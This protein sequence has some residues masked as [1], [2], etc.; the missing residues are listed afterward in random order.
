[1]KWRNRGVVALL[2]LGYCTYFIAYP[3]LRDHGYLTWGIPQDTPPAV[4]RT[5][6]ARYVKLALLDR[7][8]PLDRRS[9]DPR[10]LSV[11]EIF[12]GMR[13]LSYGR[14]ALELAGTR[15]DS[16]CASAVWGD[17]VR[18]ALARG[19]CD[20][21]IRGQYRA[22]EVGMV[23]LLV[24]FK[25]RDG[26]AAVDLLTVLDHPGS[27]FIHPLR[28]GLAHGHISGGGEADGDG[29]GHYA[30]IRWAFPQSASA[31]ADTALV[32]DALGALRSAD[33]FAFDRR[34]AVEN[35]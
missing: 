26:A 35:P 27:G 3:H 15:D 2:I 1:M 17:E 13:K 21:V 9:D 19:D 22:P 33:D 30:I 32:D 14:M 16:D 12:W 8:D 24:V 10:R 7:S 29:W 23:G 31:G 6:P 4:V 11:G 34:W 20:Q 25:L 18:A 28:P 5:R